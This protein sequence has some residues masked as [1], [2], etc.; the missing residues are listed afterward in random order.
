[1]LSKLLLPLIYPLAAAAG[2]YLRSRHLRNWNPIRLFGT[3]GTTT[4][5]TS[6]ERDSRLAYEGLRSS[7]QMTF[8]IYV[9]AWNQELIKV[10]Q[11]YPIL[12][13]ASVLVL[14]AFLDL[15][16]RGNPRARN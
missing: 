5:E 7:L 15:Q 11:S 13:V 4:A 2:P 16:P 10:W 14:A 12:T 9:A 8:F 3:P 6:S 1:M